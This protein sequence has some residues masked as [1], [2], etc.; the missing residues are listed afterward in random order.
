MPSG[1]LSKNKILRIRI[2]IIYF[3]NNNPLVKI[4]NVNKRHETSRNFLK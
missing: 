3:V 1:L 4:N 2:K